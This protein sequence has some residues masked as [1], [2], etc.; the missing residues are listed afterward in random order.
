MNDVHCDFTPDSMALG[1]FRQLAEGLGLGDCPFMVV[2]VWRNVADEPVQQWP[3]AVCDASSVAPSDLI[4]RI[5]PENENT[6]YNVLASDRHRWFTYSA[7]SADEM[8]LFKQFDSDDSAH[9]FTPHTAFDH[10]R[11]ISGAPTR[12]SCEVRVL[13]FFD[14]ERKHTAALRRLAHSDSGV[15]APEYTTT[16]SKI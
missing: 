9:R 7:L 12:Q 2:N 5:S 14:P 10:P 1:L 4:P 3:M 15:V 8:L 16:T 6:I 13:C 11:T